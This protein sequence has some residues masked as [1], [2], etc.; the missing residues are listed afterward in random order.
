MVDIDSLGGTPTA[1]DFEFAVGNDDDPS[2]WAAAAAPVSITV[3]S[4]A[5]VDSSDRVTIIWA[6]GAIEKQW[7]QVTVLATTNTDLIDDD[8]FYF[9][10]AIGEIGNS[11]TDARVTPTDEI[12]V[13]NN[14]ASISVNPAE[15]DNPYDFNRDRKVSPTDMILCRNN[16]T[17]SATALQLIIP[18]LE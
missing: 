9:G 14:P 3:R 11:P 6:D 16:G 5:G 4:G 18:P 7:L 8:V 10:N 12:G 13:R 17:S 15:I 1:A 2:G